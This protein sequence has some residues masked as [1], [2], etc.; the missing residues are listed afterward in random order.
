MKSVLRNLRFLAFSALF[1]ITG[2][3]GSANA[4]QYPSKPITLVTGYAAGAAS[5]TLARALAE[6]L[7]QQWGQPVVVD[8]RPGS[9]GNIA[10]AFVARSAPDGYN[11]LVATDAM[12]TSNSYLF[13]AIS[14]DP[15]KDFAPVLN[16]AAN[17]LVLAVHPDQPIQSVSDYIA[18]AKKNPGKMTFG[19]SGPGSPHHLAG[20]LLMQMAD[21]KL[22]HIPYKGGGQTINDLAGGHIPS[23]FLSLSAAKPLHDG[24]KIRI[25]GVAEPKRYSELPNIPTIAETLPG[26]EM[27]SF[28]ALMAP[29][30][31]PPDVIAK[32]SEASSRILRDAGISKKLAGAGLVVT[33]TPPE[34]LAKTIKEGLDVRGKLIKASGIQPE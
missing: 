22:Q 12:L 13:K 1:A 20:E 17:I 18:Q 16:A 29:A 9:S 11:I 26:F 19:S 23:A 27:Q 32:I 30:G 3:A 24:G 15:V 25:I 21:I 14:F 33:A 10:A 34:A 8:G 31:T 4:Q 5:D 6:Q 7:Q 2:A 28:V